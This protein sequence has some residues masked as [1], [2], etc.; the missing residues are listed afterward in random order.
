MHPTLRPPAAGWVRAP[1]R[2]PAAQ[3]QGPGDQVLRSKCTS[4]Q[5]HHKTLQSR[6]ICAHLNVVKVCILGHPGGAGQEACS[7]EAMMVDANYG[8]I[9]VKSAQQCPAQQPMAR[10]S[11]MPI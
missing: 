2:C 3:E 4:L 11:L 7:S 1:A 5:D 10:Q 8:L 9:R 6:Q